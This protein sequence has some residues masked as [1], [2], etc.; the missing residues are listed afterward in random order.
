MTHQI[1][2][3]RHET[4][5]RRLTVRE[6]RNV[7]PNMI[8]IVLGGDEL[9]GFV[10]LGADDHIKLMLPAGFGTGQAERRDYTPRGSCQSNANSSLHDA[11]RSMTRGPMSAGHSRNRLGRRP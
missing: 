10:S 4:K 7:T 5:R 3:E 11:V 1:T 6:K 8:R 2:R 9:A